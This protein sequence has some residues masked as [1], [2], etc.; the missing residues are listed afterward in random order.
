[1]PKILLPSLRAHF[2]PHGAL[3]SEADL[4]I[5]AGRRTEAERIYRGLSRRRLITAEACFYAGLAAE[6]LGHRARAQDILETGVERF[7]GVDWLFEQYCRVCAEAGRIDRVVRHLESSSGSTQACERIF[8]ASSHISVLVGMI[9]ICAERHLGDLAERHWKPLV[10]ECEDPEALWRLADALLVRGYREDVDAIYARLAARPQASALDCQYAGLATLRLGD[11][12]RGFGVLEQALARFPADSH[13]PS[14]FLQACAARGDLDRYLR[15]LR[16]RGAQSVDTRVECLK[17]YRLAVSTGAPEAVVTNFKEI[18]SILDKADFDLLKKEFFAS[19]RAHPPAFPRAKELLFCSRYFDAD[20]A[21]ST[22]LYELLDGL[23]PTGNERNRAL[24]RLLNLL[25]PPLVRHYPVDGDT[26]LR[27]FVQ[28]ADLLCES[29]I[30]LDEPLKDMTSN[31]IPWQS[32]FCAVAPALYPDAAAAL[33]RMAVKTWPKLKY[34]AA[35]TLRPTA[36]READ[37]RIRIG[38]VVQDSMPMM[39][40]LLS[41][42]DPAR[43]ET[44][45][46]RPGKAGTTKVATDWI[47]RAQRTV[48]FSETDAY[49]AIETIA[50]EELDIIVS[51]P[52]WGPVLFPMMA[53]LAT[54]QMVLLEPSWTDGMSN[55]DYYISWRS[56]EPTDPAAFYRSATSLLE[57]PPYWIER[58]VP[59]RDAPLS[60]EKRLDVR[61]RIL[62]G[63]TARRFYLCANTPPKI[64][65]DMD[66]MVDDLLEKDPSGV[67]VLLRGDNPPAKSLKARLQERLGAKY[68]RVL[69]L[70]G[71][72]RDDAHAL[73]QAVD[74]CLDS[75]PICGMSSSFDGAMLGVPIVTLP[76]DIPFGRWTAAIYEYIGVTDLIA[77]DR[78]HYVDL[79]VRL[80]A[81]RAWRESLSADI[82][83]KAVRYVESEASANEFQDFILKAWDRKVNGLPPANWVEGNWDAAA[84]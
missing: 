9:P 33:E 64:H 67:F 75:F 68:E 12:E 47:A 43:F 61:R 29:A 36:G 41:R 42:L 48:Q 18:E 69:F 5:A 66:E 23:V 25:T 54:L 83:A 13:L 32:L 35:H 24:L 30:E 55:S 78:G 3:W 72:K 79:A 21:F 27:E 84:S 71:L 59:G 80:A 17:L 70:P 51:G 20:D 53:R 45:Y 31:W 49:S 34:T 58:S 19:L 38:F 14:V 2:A 50:G 82:K 10:T 74:C 65:P 26:A 56:A 39:S 57:H 76:S 28:T 60:E 6:R 16:T 8:A 46:L 44:V 63:D 81:D 11:T 22:E 77:R 15:Y 40:G 4:A 7:P 52:S 37:R 73:L 62:G 1:M